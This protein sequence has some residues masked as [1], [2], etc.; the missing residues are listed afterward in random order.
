[1]ERLLKYSRSEPHVER[2]SCHAR[3]FYGERSLEDNHSLE[4]VVNISSPKRKRSQIKT[5]PKARYPLTLIPE[6]HLEEKPREKLREA[7]S[8]HIGRISRIRALP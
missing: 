7:R 4:L 2:N 1:M 3:T 5:R 6:K 8:A